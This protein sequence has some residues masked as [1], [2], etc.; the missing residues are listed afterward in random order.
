MATIDLTSPVYYRAGVS[1]VSAVVGV[2]SSCN[3]VVRYSFTAPDTGASAVSLS[4]SG[5]VLGG[6][7]RPASL[8][9]YIGTDPTS[10]INA[11]PG[12]TST[13]TLSLSGT[14]YAG[15]A[16]PVLLPGQS[17]YLFL[18]PVTADYGWYSLEL[19][20]VSLTAS[21]G[22]YSVPTASA[23]TVALGTAVTIITN[24][25][26]T[27]LTHTLTYV[28]GGTSGTI[29]TGVGDSAAWTP[30][31]SLAKQIPNALS[32]TAVIYCTT[33]HGTTQVGPVQSLRLTLQVPASVVPTVSATWRD[34][35]GAASL[36]LLV[37]L[38]SKLAVTV[39]AAGAQGSTVTATAVTLNGKAYTGGTLGAAGTLPLKVTVTD[40]RGR[41]ASASYSLTVTDYAPPQLSVSASRCDSDGTANDT[42]E[43]CT[44]TLTGQTAQLGG[45]NTAALSLTYGSTTE[46]IAVSTGSFTQSLVVAA[47]S[48]STLNIS[49]TLSDALLSVK[50]SMTL[51]VGFATMD[52]LQ[53]GKGI[54]MGGIATREGFHCAMPAYFTGGVSGIDSKQDIY[55]STSGINVV[56][57]ASDQRLNAQSSAGALF[58]QDLNTPA[59]YG[60]F[61]YYY[62]HSTVL[63]LKVL[64]AENL[65][66]ESNAVGTIVPRDGDGV[67]LINY[68]IAVL[69]F[70]TV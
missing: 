67:A 66:W 47:S 33:Y 31:V 9:F 48:A 60:L 42:G 32:G 21:G 65:S 35:S 23:A 41:T 12:S 13:G 53:G 68:K 15:S 26:S 39:N 30:P 16:S 49:A 69:P 6:G 50:Q 7:T 20:S 22:S 43:Y 18:F 14:D 62:K 56:Y 51:S 28:F 2:E 36:G 58:I 37:K 11:G 1:G 46:S 63:N 19:A 52:F 45:K 8:G 34:T 17:Y 3:R 38:V 25:Q 70:F 40:S 5:L 27:A 55:V 10:H 24:R 54:A 57:H 44:I 64:Q 4:L 29:A 61:L 59:R